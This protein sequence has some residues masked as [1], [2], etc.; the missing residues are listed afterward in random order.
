M[1]LPYTNNDFRAFRDVTKALQ[2]DFS[3]QHTPLSLPP[4]TRLLLQRFIDG[5][6]G[7]VGEEEAARAHVELRSFS[8]RYVGENPQKIGL[9]MSV[10][11]LLRPAL[12]GDASIMFWARK[13]VAVVSSAGF[14]RSALEDAQDF[15]VSTMILEIDDPET[16]QR[17]KLASR[18]CKDLLDAYMF[19]GEEVARDHSINASANAQVMKQLEDVL[20]TFGRKRLKDFFNSIDDFVII[21]EKRLQALTLLNSYLQHQT[22]HLYL[23]TNTPLL[24]NLLKC[25]MND[26]S[27]TVLSVAL[28][29]LVMLLP[30]IPGS[31]EPYLPRLFLVY[32][33]ILCFERF[34]ELSTE[35]Q[36]N[37]VTD[38]RMTYEEESDAVGDE[39]EDF[40]TNLKW[41]K[42]RPQPGMV[43]AVTPELMTYFT[44]LYGLY[45]LNLMSYI[46]KPRRYLK[47]FEFPNADGFDLDPAVIRSRTEQF[48]QLHL[49][50]PNFYNLTVE[51][52]LTDSKWSTMDPADVVGKCQALCTF[53]KLP[54]VTS[55]SLPPG[56]LPDVPQMPPLE[57]PA[58]LRAS[59]L[60]PTASYTSLRSGSSWRD[61]QSTA[62]SI[63][64]KDDS[65]IAKA[66]SMLSGNEISSPLLETIDAKEDGDSKPPTNIAYLQREITLLRNDLNFE[67][68]HKS[69]YSEH[70]SQ[71]MRRNVKQATV[72]AETLNLIN[73]NRA[74]KRQLEQVQKA[75]EATIKDSALTRKQVNT[76]EANMTQRF[77]ELK[78]EQETWQADADE[79]RRLRTETKQYRDLLVATEA[80]DLTKS[81]QLEIAR[82][83]LDGLGKIEDKLREV[84]RRLR[85]FEDREIE[86]IIAMRERDVLRKANSTLRTR[87]GLDLPLADQIEGEIGLTRSLKRH[88]SVPNRSSPSTLA[89]MSSSFTAHQ[90]PT[91]RARSRT[92]ASR[93]SKR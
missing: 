62:A 5:H 35:D 44:Y 63:P 61:T 6:D 68:W 40:G 12:L 79:L 14:A 42:A 8:E 87:L 9:F 16:S 75:R 70:I 76:L 59:A 56:K 3:A 22:P 50:H 88:L 21:T 7:K 41:Q 31:L 1:C 60:S 92:V 43:E 81:H 55:N 33:R 4:E 27:T 73:A 15:L 49:V 20:I 48:R 2:R 74:L 25:L 66:E 52:E 93:S 54:V 85:G 39:K 30:H 91:G 38:D 86:I 84:S 90:T 64:K 11:R 18:L 58:S 69:Q 57:G 89:P 26:T 36:K 82:R 17:S 28:N 13:A 67:R 72:E 78:L 29:S 53:S 77:N 80:R 34:S 51:E 71:I 83:E 45:P 47:S 32:S 19:R 65:S 24:E 37:L 23:V 46:R 10:L